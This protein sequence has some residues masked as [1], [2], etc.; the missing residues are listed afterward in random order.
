MA[1]CVMIQEL[2][3]YCLC[4]S[5]TFEG[6]FVAHFSLGLALRQKFHKNQLFC[7]SG[8]NKS[9]FPNFDWIFA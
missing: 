6:S 8:S 3:V 7:V 4:L 5:P 1:A 2:I 9:F